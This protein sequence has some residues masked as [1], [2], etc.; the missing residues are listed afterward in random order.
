MSGAICLSLKALLTSCNELK[1][2]RATEDPARKAKGA[3]SFKG[4]MR[5]L[6]QQIRLD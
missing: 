5:T 2:G 1:K 4:G 3:A 6:D